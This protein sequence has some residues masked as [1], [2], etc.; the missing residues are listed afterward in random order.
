MLTR[1]EV[2]AGEANGRPACPPWL[3]AARSGISSALPQV[4]FVSLTA[5]SP[6]TALQLPAEAHDSESTSALPRIGSAVPQR[7]FFWP[8]TKARAPAPTA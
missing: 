7:P 6:P 8:T 1:P 4:T 5:N 2:A 3:S